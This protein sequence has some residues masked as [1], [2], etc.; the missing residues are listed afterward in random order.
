MTMFPGYQNDDVS[1]LSEGE[2][3]EVHIKSHP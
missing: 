2:D 3:I 1:E